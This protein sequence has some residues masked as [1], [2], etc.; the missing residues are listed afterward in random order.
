M[1]QY[2]NTTLNNIK[3]KTQFVFK[4]D[5]LLN[6]LQV[7][8]SIFIKEGLEYKF[9]HRSLQEYFT[10]L[11][12]KNLSENAKK[13]V[14]SE[15]FSIKNNPFIDERFNLWELSTELD[16]TSFYK[17][18]VIPNLKYIVASFDLNDVNINS[19]IIENF[20]CS[21]GF[22]KDFDW[23]IR[24]MSSFEKY[25]SLIQYLNIKL[26]SIMN[27]D[28]KYK[29]YP[30]FITYL[31][32]NRC[33]D[34]TRLPEGETKKDIIYTI[35]MSKRSKDPDFQKIIS[36]IGFFTEVHEL[37]KE[38]QSKITELENELKMESTIDN[39]LINLI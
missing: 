9:P 3:E 16:K 8:I 30:T 17:Y 19:L 2:L 1:I 24:Y 39:D 7:A 15:K 34:I 21:I 4:N 22:N 18:F 38:I 32:K 14:Y 20:G 25:Y 11:F 6:D 36:D 29:N 12:I 35:D 33:N 26:S 5:L 28:V 27:F 10:A 31:Q 23:R 37:L 13:T